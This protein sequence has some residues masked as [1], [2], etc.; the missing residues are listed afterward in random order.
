M[1][2]PP[3]GAPVRAASAR[4]VHDVVHG[5]RS[6]DDALAQA[7]TGLPAADR[8]LARM[9]TFGTLRRFWQL[10]EWI[11]LL[12]DRPARKLDGMVRALLAVGLYQFVDTRIPDH[13]V[14]S[15]TVDAAR[16]LKRP[17]AAGLVNAVLRRFLRE[18]VAERAPAGEE[19]AFN[20]PQW[21]IDGLKRDWPDDWRNILAANDERAPMWLR[22]NA[23]RTT[24]EGYRARLEAAGYRA[25][26]APGLPWALCLEEPVAVQDL[27]G[28]ADGDVSV[29]DAAAQI[30]A[31]WLLDGLRGDILDA[32]A[33]PGGKGAHLAELGGDGVRLTA[34]DADAGRLRAVVETFARL[35][36]RATIVA[37][38]ASK[39]GE[40]AEQQAFDGI[41]VDAPCSATGVIRRHPDIKHLRRP[42]DIDALAAVQARILDALWLRLRPGGRLLYVTCSVMAREN[43][44]VVADFLGR[45]LD[46]RE[47]RMLQNNNIRDVMRPKA[48]GFQLLPGTAGMDG[49]FFASLEKVA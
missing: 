4:A 5:G 28:F 29:Q 12:T 44:A 13:A 39:P 6:L 16:L 17:R 49:F 32:C 2:A 41:L 46:A 1:N 40:W 19:A 7:E 26:A 9:L 27:P 14:V 25:T 22:V 37:G 24:T 45:H 10:D 33:A 38:D 43:D 48:C 34:I 3:P 36:L 18:S 30:A 31:P 20:H 8:S 47:N 21:L 42:G 35:G 15:P 11:A 23:C